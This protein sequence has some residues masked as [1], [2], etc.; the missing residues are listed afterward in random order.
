MMADLTLLLQQREKGQLQ[1]PEQSMFGMWMAQI[2]L[3]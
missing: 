1:T 2:H 3:Y